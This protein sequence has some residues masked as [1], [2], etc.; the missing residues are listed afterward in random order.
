MK[1]IEEPPDEEYQ[2]Y[3]EKLKV[4]LVAACETPVHESITNDCTLLIVESTPK[5][6]TSSLFDE[7]RIAIK[8]ALKD[9]FP[10]DF[11]GIKTVAD[12]VTSEEKVFKEKPVKNWKRKPY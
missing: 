11:E 7:F 10:T 3:K 2:A 5:E 9:E 12:I 1:W 4:A 6:A 8:D